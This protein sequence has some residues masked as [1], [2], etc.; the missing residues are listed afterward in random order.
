MNAFLT[1][2]YDRC[3]QYPV[4]HLICLPSHLLARDFD[5]RKHQQM[6]AFGV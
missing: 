3:A 5:A 1:D 6:R 4:S 2:V